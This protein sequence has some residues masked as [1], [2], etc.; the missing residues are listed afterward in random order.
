ML[1]KGF[2]KDDTNIETS[3]S[4]CPITLSHH[5]HLCKICSEWVVMQRMHSSSGFRRTGMM[6]EGIKLKIW[7]MYK[8]ACT[9]KNIHTRLQRKKKQTTSLKDENN[10]TWT[11]GRHWMKTTW[12]TLRRYKCQVRWGNGVESDSFGFLRVEHGKGTMDLCWSHA[13]CFWSVM[14]QHLKLFPLHIT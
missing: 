14:K 12:P 11:E 3:F 9:H 8:G 1:F 4:I 13:R 2:L 6:E 5:R 7:V 10:V